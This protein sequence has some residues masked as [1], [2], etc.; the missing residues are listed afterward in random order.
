M[1]SGKTTY[2][3]LPFSFVEEG[4]T[5]T[6]NLASHLIQ[7]VSIDGQPV[8]KTREQSNSSP[9][10]TSSASFLRSDVDDV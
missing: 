3:P 8:E 2:V 9:G 6:T 10:S 4:T 1:E 7:S 5:W